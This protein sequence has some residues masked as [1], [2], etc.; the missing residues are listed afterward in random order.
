MTSF[1]RRLLVVVVLFAVALS[2]SVAFAG[3][4]ATAVAAKS[5]EARV[6]FA[7]PNPFIPG[8]LWT[9]DLRVVATDDAAPVAYVDYRVT[10]IST[11]YEYAHLTGSETLAPEQV[12][13]G[14]LKSAEVQDVVVTVTTEP[15]GGFQVFTFNVTWTRSGSPTVINSRD[16]GEHTVA[17]LIPTTVTGTATAP[18]PGGVFTFSGADVTAS[19]LYRV[20]VATG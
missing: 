19:S 3:V 15:P 12:A 1:L 10:Q 14:T 17:Q 6:S 16:G 8:I 4:S 5:W 20:L 9:V 11:G 7:H 2:A 13:L 18:I